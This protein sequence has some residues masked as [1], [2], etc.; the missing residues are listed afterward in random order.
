MAESVDLLI[1]AGHMFVH[2]KVYT[3][4]QMQNFVGL[5]Q[6]RSKM[7]MQTMAIAMRVGHHAENKD[8][9]KFMDVE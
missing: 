8:F 4:R 7:A 6:K 3:L 2:I 1:S 5:F 9:Q